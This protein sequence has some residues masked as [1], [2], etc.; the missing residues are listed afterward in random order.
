MRLYLDA[1][2]RAKDDSAALT[3]AAH[4]LVRLGREEQA[5]A[6]LREAVRRQPGNATAWFLLG[7]T[8]DRQGD[9]A[10]AEAAFRRVAELQPGLAVAHGNL[11]ALARRRGAGGQAVLAYRA[12]ARLEPGNPDWHAKLAATLHQARRMEEAVPAM[13]RH[14]L[15][16]PGNADAHYNL[17]V[18]LPLLGWRERGL[19]HLTMARA[20]DPRAAAVHA[21][22]ARLSRRLGDWPAAAGAA[23]RSLVIDPAD[24]E[25]CLIAAA[26]C[27][28]ATAMAEGERMRRHAQVLEPGNADVAAGLA[29][30]RGNPTEPAAAALDYRRW[31]ETC[32][33]AEMPPIPAGGPLI[34]VILPVYDPREDLLEAAIAS[35]ER[36]SYPNWQLCIADD[37]SP[38]PHVR[39]VLEAAAARDRRTVVAFRR[40]NGHIAHASNSALDLA[41]GDYV[42]FLDHDDLLAPDA[43]LHVA[44]AIAGTPSL[45]LV[46][47]DEDKIDEAGARLDPHFKP[48][49]DAE[50]LASQNFVCHLAVYRRALV[51]A[52]GRLRPGTEGSQDHDLVLRVSERTDPSRIR[53][54]PHVLYHWRAIAGSTALDVQ[55]K[56]YVLAATRRVLADHLARA[57]IAGTVSVTQSGWRVRRALPDPAP[58]VSVVIPTR[59]RHGLLAAC[60]DGLVHGTDYPRLE[61][62]IVD[63]GSS[64]P[65]ALALLD[66]LE[67]AGTARVLRRP[68]QFNWAALTNDGARASR[69]DVLLLLNN[70]IEPLVPDWLSE[71]VSHAVRPGVGAVGA[72][73]LYPDGTVQHAGVILCGDNVARHV[74][75]GIKGDAGGYWGRANQVQQFS[76]VTGACVAVRRTAFEAVG[77]LDAGRFLVDFAD[78]DFCLRLRAAGLR[79]VWTPHAML[80]HHESASRGSFATVA[81]AARYEVERQA[82]VARWG[83]LLDEDPFYSPNLA[84]APGSVPYTLAI[85]PRR[86][87][88]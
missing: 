71:L 72:K 14:A 48:D 50:L 57:G 20:I 51:E 9:G 79:V 1:A 17:G 68:G 6:A 32:E 74:H 86:T 81:K 63:N 16:L 46:Y 53:H 40:E 45:D 83:R 75:V 78:I 3:R 21:R 30:A 65:A 26:A 58:M 61:I 62:V 22:I 54:I 41:E 24:F 34:S 18:T 33:P 56:P 39:K 43:L 47:T 64:E 36:Q 7:E 35:V 87:A 28:R 37:A 2:R 52:V 76:A 19:V 12:A 49:F 84:V 55:Y 15:L 67:R 25:P 11:A 27:E 59:D 82:M 38:S 44:H 23:R 85:P 5:I 60:I 66:H 4:L 29:R 77:G 80:T 13:L 8:S 31:I 88:G 70:D 10:A 42:A 69:G 73:L